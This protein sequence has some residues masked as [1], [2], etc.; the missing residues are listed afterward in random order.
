MIS[1]SGKSQW[2]AIPALRKFVSVLW[3]NV[4]SC[5]RQQWNWNRAA[6]CSVQERDQRLD[7]GE[8]RMRKKKE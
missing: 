3:G 5:L 8:K 2:P 4:E 6:V 7:F 1:I